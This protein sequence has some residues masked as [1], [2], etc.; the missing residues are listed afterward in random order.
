[1]EKLV[2]DISFTAQERKGESIAID[3]AFVAKQLDDN[4]QLFSRALELRRN[5]L[6][7]S[8][9]FHARSSAVSSSCHACASFK[10]LQYLNNVELWQ[11]QCQGESKVDD[12]VMHLEQTIQQH[13][14]LLETITDA[15]NQV[16]RLLRFSL[17]SINR[18]WEMAKQCCILF[19]RHCSTAIC[20]RRSK[21]ISMSDLA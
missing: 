4:W 21:S 11:R 2:E 6:Q 18:W 16:L 7:L 9:N 17:R 20:H 14:Q 12:D 5:I 1:M 3:K 10:T 19:S 13:Q 8:V 15:Y